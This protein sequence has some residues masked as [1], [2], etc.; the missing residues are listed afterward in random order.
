MNFGCITDKSIL[1]VSI[2]KKVVMYDSVTVSNSQ[3]VKQ[4]SFSV[5]SLSGEPHELE[6][7][8]CFVQPRWHVLEL[9][10]TIGILAQEE[11]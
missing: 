11:P 4:G 6:S 9:S 1:L 10:L 8:C 2:Y 7:W 3:T 5:Q